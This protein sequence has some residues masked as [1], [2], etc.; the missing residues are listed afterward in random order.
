MRFRDKIRKCQL[1]PELAQSRQNI[2]IGDGPIPCNL[3]FL[4]E[5]PGQKEDEKGVPFIGTSGTHLRTVAELVGLKPGSYHILNMLK[6][7][8][9]LNR[10]PTFIEMQNCRPFLLQQLKSLKPKVVVVLGRYSLSFALDV[11][12]NKVIVSKQSGKIIRRPDF[13]DIKFLGTYHPAFVLRKRYT[14]VEK[15]FRQ[16]LRKAKRLA[17]EM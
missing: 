17:Y 6:C 14:D 7:R 15:A 12:P 1:C 16:H 3:V 10:D 5:A 4:G 2:V 11:R 13:P 9:P 8:P